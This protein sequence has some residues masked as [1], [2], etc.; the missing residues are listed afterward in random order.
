MEWTAPLSMTDRNQSHLVIQLNKLSW[1]VY[2]QSQRTVRDEFG[3][4]QTLQ[5]NVKKT[6]TVNQRI[7]REYIFIAFLL[8]W[9]ENHVALQQR[10]ILLKYHVGVRPHIIRSGMCKSN[11]CEWFV[12]VYGTISFCMFVMLVWCH[13]YFCVTCFVISRRYSQKPC[14]P[15]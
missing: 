10:Q 6:R 4:K 2:W 14:I 1:N 7:I 9:H 11:C 15:R 13:A 8:K 3:T 5:D 12:E